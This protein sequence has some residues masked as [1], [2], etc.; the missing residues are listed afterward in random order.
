M[1]VYE[2]VENVCVNSMRAVGGPR[3]LTKGG[4]GLVGHVRGLVSL[5]RVGSVISNI[6]IIG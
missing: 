4:E 1:F 5:D 3:Y 6:C 2:W